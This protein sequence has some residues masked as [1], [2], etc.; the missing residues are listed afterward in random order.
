M[1]DEWI[2]VKHK[3]HSKKPKN[4]NLSFDGFRKN[5]ENPNQD[6]NIIVLNKPKIQ[7]YEQRTQINKEEPGKLTK[8]DIENA[9]RKGLVESVKKTDLYNSRTTSV[10]SKLIETLIDDPNNEFHQKIIDN[11]TAINIQKVRVALGMTQKDLA[12]KINEKVNIV[13]EYETGT[14]I[15]DN[16]V[17]LKLERVLGIKITSK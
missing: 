16:N 11:K 7:R 17:T 15:P 5:I 3:K 12:F 9:K 2:T 14:C 1:S 6:H 8:K 10:N 13:N 4:E